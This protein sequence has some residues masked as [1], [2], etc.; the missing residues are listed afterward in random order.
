M[1][2]KPVNTAPSVPTPARTTIN[3]RATTAI[4]RSRSVSSTRWSPLGTPAVPP[5]GPVRS[6]TD[7]GHI[8][9]VGRGLERSTPNAPGRW[10][11]AG[12][13]HVSHEF[14]GGNPPM[15]SSGSLSRRVPFRPGPSLTQTAVLVERLTLEADLR[16]ALVAGDL[17]LRYQP[18]VDLHRGHVVAFE[19]LCRWRHWARGLLGPAQFLPPATE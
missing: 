16:H 6:R 1:N 5:A 15:P 18:I 14:H 13:Q 19:T 8:G 11:G 3:S 7:T 9:L 10:G 17:V 2:E 4:L 12:H